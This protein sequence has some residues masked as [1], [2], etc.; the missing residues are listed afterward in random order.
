MAGREAQAMSEARASGESDV[1]MVPARRDPAESLWW[2]L[3]TPLLPATLAIPGF[4]WLLPLL[5]PLSVHAA[6]ARR[7]RERRY[8]A[9]WTIGMAWALLLSLGFLGLVHLRLNVATNGIL[10]GTEYKSEM[11]QWISSGEGKESSPAL[12]LPEH[13]AHLGAFLLLT[14]ASGGYLGLALGAYLLGYMSFYV[15]SFATRTGVVGGLAAWPPWAILRVA[16]FVLFLVVLARPLLVR[17]TDPRWNRLGR[18]EWGLLAIALAGVIAD[19]LLKT[20][21]APH[22]SLMLRN[23][24][25]RTVQ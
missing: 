8:G 18:R 23:L 7:V 11:Q 22:W 13:L 21:L 10:H 14:L 6:L 9:A 15:G 20:L 12:F 2:L 19:A 1:A 24:L 4:R 5:A 17:R 16:A 25:L 3:L